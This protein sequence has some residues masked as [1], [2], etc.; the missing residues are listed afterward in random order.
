MTRPSQLTRE[1][2][3]CGGAA[4]TIATLLLW[5]GPPGSDLAAHAY[6]RSVF[7]QHGFALWNNFWY[8]GRYSF[9]TYS[10]IYYP[11]AG[12]LGIKLLAVL[13][14]A[15]AAFAF[16]TLLDGEF[17]PT[18]HW[19]SLTFAVLWG[20]LVLSG[21]FP[22]ALGVT[23]L[24]FAL[25]ALQHGNRWG[26]GALAA[27]T[28]AASPLAFLILTLVLA[29]VGVARWGDRRRL[30]V[31]AAIVGTFGAV[32][33]LLWRLF[34]D[35]GRYP[36]SREEF[37]AACTFCVVGAAMTWRV[38]RARVLRWLFVVYLAACVTAFVVPSSLGENV[39]RLRFA[40]LPLVVL[41][42]S[43]RN[44]KPLPVCVA[45]LALGCSWNVTPLA[46]SFVQSE[47]DPAASQ[48]YWRPATTY[49]RDVLT[50]AYRVEAVDTTGHWDAVYLP[51]AGIPLAR[52]WY[53]QNDFP[54]NR[55][56]YDE[57]AKR[58][59]LEWLRSLGV[60]YVV[61][62]DAPSDYSAR[63]EAKL[64]RSGRSGLRPVF[65]SDHVTVYAVP[66]PRPLLT[67]PGLPYV[68]KL[69]QAHVDIRLHRAGL[70]RLAVRYS[71]YWRA[72]AGCLSRGVDGMVRIST[73]RPVTVHLA[74]HVD[75][76]G[77]FAALAG[78]HSRG[79][80]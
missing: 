74:F 67:G 69:T 29:G 33:I 51:R 65:A 25:L 27:L 61:L 1:A 71:P 73:A 7:L 4:A 17:G 11:L 55:L 47:N 21:A 10:L 31:P 68:W 16:A 26:F 9:V 35:G 66:R 76:H 22:F 44:W 38:E 77:A 80:P 36:F 70:Y 50:P 6:Q 20:C 78:R 45:V 18:A 48:E 42:L 49:L 72:T 58:S 24:L 46:F 53:R 59:Y 30:V 32:E 28:L 57:L 40:A 75:A 14:I 23:L 15:A 12:L 41:I 5:L 2:V 64:I 8:A 19:S 39:A 37:A 54:Q 56:L 63:G 60:G 52:G 43:L 62:T 13:T 79:C 3:A 34:P